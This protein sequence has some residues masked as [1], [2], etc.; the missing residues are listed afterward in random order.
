MPITR[1]LGNRFSRIRR[2][3]CG[4]DKPVSSTTSPRLRSRSITLPVQRFLGDADRDATL[5]KLAQ[6]RGGGGDPDAGFACQGTGPRAADVG[7]MTGISWT[8]KT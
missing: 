6:E 3:I 5:A 2:Q 8:D 7:A 4:Y 1:L